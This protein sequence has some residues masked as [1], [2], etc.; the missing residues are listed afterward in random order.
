MGGPGPRPGISEN[1]PSGPAT[2]VRSAAFCFE[3]AQWRKVPTPLTINPMP[4]GSLSLAEYPTDLV[5]PKCSKCGRSGQYRKATLIG[6]YGADGGPSPPLPRGAIGAETTTASAQAQPPL[7][8]PLF[9][10]EFV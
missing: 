8:E 9:R 2:L 4:N 6:K 7:F 1:G 5:R 10:H 3:L